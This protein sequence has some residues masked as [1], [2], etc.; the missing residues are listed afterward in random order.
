MKRLILFLL[1]FISFEGFSNVS[2]ST[3]S[4]SKMTEEEKK[5]EIAMASQYQNY[6]T[7]LF[8]DFSCSVL[9]D[10]ITADNLNLSEDY[11]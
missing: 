10:G 9:K 2:A 6:L 3:I 11:P 7:N 1:I 5:A 8:T 4:D